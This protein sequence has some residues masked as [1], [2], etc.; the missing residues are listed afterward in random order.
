MSKWY[1]FLVVT[2]ISLFFQVR[3]F[4]PLA[5]SRMMACIPQQRVAHALRRAPPAKRLGDLNEGEVRGA[6]GRFALGLARGV[7]RSMR[8]SEEPPRGCPR[9]GCPLNAAH[10]C[11]D[12]TTTSEPEFRISLPMPSTCEY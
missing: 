2:K 6:D 7:R 8:E 10:P 9:T 3:L 1:L 12:D 5:S 4:M 11:T